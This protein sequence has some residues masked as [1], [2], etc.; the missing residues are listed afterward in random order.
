MPPL[1]CTRHADSS[2]TTEQNTSKNVTTIRLSKC[3]FLLHWY[4]TTP[5]EQRDWTR[6]GGYQMKSRSPSVLQWRPIR[7]P[8]SHLV[9]ESDNGRPSHWIYLIGFH[10]WLG[11]FFMLILQG[12]LR[13]SC[14]LGKLGP[15]GPKQSRNATHNGISWAYRPSWTGTQA[16]EVCLSVSMQGWMDG[17]MVLGWMY[18][19]YSPYTSGS[20]ENCFPKPGRITRHDRKG[21]HFKSW[22]ARK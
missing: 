1:K 5:P 10:R 22:L 6:T 11:D 17:W 7:N 15:Y 20:T 3:S 8:P 19:Q 2:N 4:G 12:N 14:Q 18:V 13:W 16:L 21:C 9:H